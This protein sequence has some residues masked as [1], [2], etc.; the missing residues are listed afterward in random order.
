MYLLS[1]VEVARNSPIRVENLQHLPSVYVALY[2]AISKHR[3]SLTDRL[4]ECQ[5]AMEALNTNLLEQFFLSTVSHVNATFR[6]V[7]KVIDLTDSGAVSPEIGRPLI[8]E[9]YRRVYTHANYWYVLVDGVVLEGIFEAAGDE[10]LQE[11]SNA[12][13]VSE[14]ALLEGVFDPLTT[15]H[16]VHVDTAKVRR[17]RALKAEIEGRLE[18]CGHHTTILR[19][20]RFLHLYDLVKRWQPRFGELSASTFQRVIPRL[21]EMV[22]GVATDVGV[23]VGE[24]DAMPWRLLDLI[25][26]TILPACFEHMGPLGDVLAVHE[27]RR[28]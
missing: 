24:E 13:D 3:P 22:I 4:A 23:T 27:P 16:Y 15:Y 2:D 10:L 21:R 14:L 26:E 1:D 6:Y 12:A 25:D 20:N 28:M 18:R 19:L 17:A 5:Q 11:I 9:A 8:C 7:E